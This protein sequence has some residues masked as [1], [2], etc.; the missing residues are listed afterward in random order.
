MI[1]GLWD[2]LELYRNVTD[3][4]LSFNWICF[5]SNIHMQNKPRYFSS[6][7]ENLDFACSPCPCDSE[8]ISSPPGSPLYSRNTE[9]TKNSLSFKKS[10]GFRCFSIMWM[11]RNLNLMCIRQRLLW[12]IHS[13]TL[14]M[15]LGA[16]WP[17]TVSL[18]FA[19]PRIRHWPF[20]FGMIR[21][22]ALI[23]SPENCCCKPETGRE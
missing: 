10:F 18:D 14:W 6:N 9:H 3:H 1:V 23:Q 22:P 21:E 20:S 7:S 11:P 4:H 2:I 13:V 17:L 5:F 8:F 16:H 19:Y 12:T 15:D